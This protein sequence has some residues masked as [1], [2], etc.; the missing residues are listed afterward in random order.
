MIK[1]FFDNEIPTY[2][3]GPYYGVGAWKPTKSASNEGF[4]EKKAM[5][6]LENINKNYKQMMS[7][8]PDY[9]SSGIEVLCNN[10]QSNKGKESIT[11]LV[12]KLNTILEKTTANLGIIFDEVNKKAESI[13]ADSDGINYQ[14]VPFEAQD[15]SFSAANAKNDQ[16]AGNVAQWDLTETNK[17]VDKIQTFMKN[18]VHKNMDE[19]E[20][21]MYNL[22][23]AFEYSEDGKAVAGAIRSLT[24]K[25][26]NFAR[27]VE[28]GLESWEDDYK[29][30]ASSHGVNVDE[31]VSG[32]NGIE[33]DLDF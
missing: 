4:D 14:A 25:I 33:L 22:E 11:T 6:A 31:L 32:T 27:T 15:D 3:T 8:V 21:E 9:Q 1:I 28:K 17:G 7:A 19:I 26:E 20:N 30:D 12:T 16:E 29:T 10:W 18:R 24:N 13:D 23:A 5:E 2:G